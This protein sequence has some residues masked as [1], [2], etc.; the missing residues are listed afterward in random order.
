[1]ALDPYFNMKS[2]IPL[3]GLRGENLIDRGS[4]APIS[5]DETK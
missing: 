1:M 4:T 5:E 3:Y 2:L